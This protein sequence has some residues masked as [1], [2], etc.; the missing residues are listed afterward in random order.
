[1][2]IGKLNF[3]ESKL[4][5]VTDL[6]L[7][8]KPVEKNWVPFEYVENGNPQFYLEYSL[9]PHKILKVQ[10]PQVSAITHFIFPNFSISNKFFWSALWGEYVKGGAPARKVDDFYLS[11]FHTFF[12]DQ[13]NNAWYTMGAYAFDSKPPFRINAVSNYPILYKGI[14]NSPPLNTADPSK[15]VVFPGGFVERVV[16]GKKVIHLVCGEND[17]AVK[18][19]TFDKDLLIKGMKKI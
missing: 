5:Y 7:Q 2:R 17:C 16:D 10:D 6:D 4:D 15:R 14:Y 13:H 18:V 9:N 8:I 1:M 3:E 19:I 12:L 11:F